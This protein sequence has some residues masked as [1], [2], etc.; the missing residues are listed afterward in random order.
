MLK[1]RKHMP[2]LTSKWTNLNLIQ[3]QISLV[4]QFSD[5]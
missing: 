3:K 5:R 2:I 4:K 1:K